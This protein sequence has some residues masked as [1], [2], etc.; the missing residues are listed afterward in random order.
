MQRVK[1]GRSDSHEACGQRMLV[2][3]ILLERYFG[4]TGLAKLLRIISSRIQSQ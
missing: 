4:S 2:Q 3:Y 1:D